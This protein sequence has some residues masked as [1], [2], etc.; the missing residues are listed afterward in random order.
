MVEQIEH[1]RHGLYYLTDTEEPA[2]F[3]AAKSE[4]D[5][6]GLAVMARRAIPEGADIPGHRLHEHTGGGRVTI[7]EPEPMTKKQ[8]KETIDR[9]TKHLRERMLS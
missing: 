4:P 7:P 3:I 6:I 2:I 8:R 1:G 5:A 9:L